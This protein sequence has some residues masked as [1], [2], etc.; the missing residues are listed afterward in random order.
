VPRYRNPLTLLQASLR[1]VEASAVT[2]AKTSANLS[3]Q[4]AETA[5]LAVRGDVNAGGDTRVV[6]ATPAPKAGS[7]LLSLTAENWPEI[8]KELDISGMP[9]QLAN[10]CLFVSA[11]DSQ[12]SLQL[13]E[14]AAHLNT[15]RF[16]SRLQ[17]AVNEWSG[18]TLKLL[19]Q[20]TQA[21]LETP[22]RLEEAAQA[23]ELEAARV[24]IDEDPLVQNLLQ[25][26][27][28]KLDAASIEP[29]SKE[30]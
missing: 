21:E 12:C 27:D 1:L 30:T 6:P 26:V 16:A 24:A 15:E 23:A 13:Q 28:G 2:S 10:N 5:K 8:V 29:V 9:R 20:T 3:I 18:K 4:A 11:T 14:N 19:I 7:S 25:Q 17:T 22:A